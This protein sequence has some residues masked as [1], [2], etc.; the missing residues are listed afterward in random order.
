VPGLLPGVG[1]VAGVVGVLVG[2][3]V[4]VGVLPGDDVPPYGV[5]KTCKENRVPKARVVRSGV[6]LK[7]FL[8]EFAPI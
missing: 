3:D 6:G 5:A 4:L 8:I 1:E 2:V 7:I